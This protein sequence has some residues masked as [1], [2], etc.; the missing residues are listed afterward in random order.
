MCCFQ[1]IQLVF[2][3]SVSHHADDTS[4]TIALGERCKGMNQNTFGNREVISSIAVVPIVTE[5]PVALFHLDSYRQLIESRGH[6]RLAGLGWGAEDLQ[7]AVGA[8]RLLLLT[9]VA[10]VLDPEGELIHEVGFDDIDRLIAEG[11]VTGG[12]IPKLET[13]RQAVRGGVDAAVI[14]DGRV[15]H[16]MLLEIFTERGIGTIIREEATTLPVPTE[17]SP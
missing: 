14:L 12:M 6:T 5:T 11:Q 3:F 16:S 8:T 1:K 10:G 9:D 2:A 4:Q 15:P 13:C 7:A 17:V